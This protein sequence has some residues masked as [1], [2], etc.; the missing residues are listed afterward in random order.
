MKNFVKKTAIFVQFLTSPENNPLVVLDM[1]YPTPILEPLSAKPLTAGNRYQQV[2]D[3]LRHGELFCFEGTYGTAM[4]FYSWVKKQLGQQFP[5]T[6][7]TSSRLHRDKLR[8]LSQRLLVRVVNHQIDLQSSPSIPWLQEFFPEIKRFYLPFTDVLG[9]NGAYQWFT[10]GVQFP[11]L[12]HR[13]HPYY[14]VYFPTRTEHLLLF[15]SLL[16]QGRDISSAL[17][18]GTGCG[19]LSFYMLK[20]GVKSVLATDINP[21]AIHSLNLDQQRLGLHDKIKTL[22]ADLL[23]GI[24]CENLDLVVFNPPWIPDT[25]VGSL[26]LAM[27]YQADLFERFFSSAHRALP[28]RCRLVILFSTFAQAAGL[29]VEHP[30][31]HELDNHNRFRL[32]NHTQLPVNQKPSPKKSWLEQVRSHESIELW[33]LERV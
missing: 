30:V 26:D 15:D 25:A 7:Y 10:N 27:Y 6:S 29:T 11:G 22:E 12:N 32:V 3:G 9:I 18:M 20:H 24:C 23:E 33:E 17:D 19:V 14:G 16:G 28:Q 5:I 21:N 2:F 13:L 31:R 4:A 8:D 1:H